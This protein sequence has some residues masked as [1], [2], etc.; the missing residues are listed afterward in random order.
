MKSKKLLVG[1]AIM[2]LAISSGV[3]AYAANPQNDESK[4]GLQ[5][6]QTISISSEDGLSFD[7]I[8]KNNLPEGVQYQDEIS[9]EDAGGISLK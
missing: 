3:I 1:T 9:I 2:V 5:Y 7:N 8:D 6:Q 4:N